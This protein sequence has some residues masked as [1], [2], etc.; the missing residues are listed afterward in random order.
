MRLG[1]PHRAAGARAVARKES[2]NQFE[3]NCR[4]AD[5]FF[6]FCPR[7]PGPASLARP[8]RDAAISRLETGA[9][10]RRAFAPLLFRK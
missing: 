4:L 8:F 3:A 1:R 5:R 7:T 2:P 10:F 9:P 6:A